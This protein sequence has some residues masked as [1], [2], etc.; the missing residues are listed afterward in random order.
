M[1]RDE[2][3]AWATGKRTE[4][5]AW[6]TGKRNEGIAWADDRNRRAQAPSQGHLARPNQGCLTRC[7]RTKPIGEVWINCPLQ[8]RSQ[9]HLARP[10][11]ACVTG[12]GPTKPI[13]EV[14]IN[15]GYSGRPGHAERD[16][17]SSRGSERRDSDRNGRDYVGVQL[18]RHIVR[19]GRLDVP[20]HLDA[21]AV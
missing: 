1:E 15:C 21:L 2:A 20:R 18:D 16:E 10:D 8:A 6:A 19:P 7:G 3:I 17:A 14:W 13:G 4:G 5:I 12:C 11:Q 9:A